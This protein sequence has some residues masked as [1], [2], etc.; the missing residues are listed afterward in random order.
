MTSFSLLALSFGM[1]MDAF[2]VCVAKGATNNYDRFSVALRQGIFFGVVEAVA[3]AIGF[4]LG[5]VAQGWM[6]SF[7]HWVAFGLLV[8]LG[9]KFL[10]EAMSEFESQPTQS[11]TSFFV[12]LITAIATSVDSM[13]VGVSLALLN[14]NI[15]VACLLIGVATTMMTTLGLYMGHR[16][17]LRFGRLAM[18]IGGMVLI[19]IGSVILYTHLQTH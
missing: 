11:H 10:K 8:G 6:A 4:G 1:A 3:P 14:V 9:I 13:V 15:W 5:Q 2:A 12:L 17:G 16:L 7:D 18:V 19:C